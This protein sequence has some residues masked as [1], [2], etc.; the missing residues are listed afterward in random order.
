PTAIIS[1][2]SAALG[3][4]PGGEPA[5]PDSVLLAET[6]AASSTYPY[7]PIDT[8][9]FYTGTLPDWA[10]SEGIA[11]VDLELHTHK[12]SDFDENLPLLQAFMAWRR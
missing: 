5:D 2:H 4:F 11:A 9:C 1:Y 12:Y 10:V 6:L 8:G 3:I 7:P